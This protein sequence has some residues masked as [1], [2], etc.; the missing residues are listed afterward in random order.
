[1]QDCNTSNMSYLLTNIFSFHHILG[2]V[3]RKRLLKEKPMKNL[4]LSVICKIYYLLIASI[5]KI[6]SEQ[7]SS[8]L[9]FKHNTALT[10]PHQVK[11]I[12]NRKINKVG[13]DEDLVGW[14]WRNLVQSIEWLLR[15]LVIL[16]LNVFLAFT[17]EP[18]PMIAWL[19]E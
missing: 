12:F 10:P 4:K 14:N 8:S 3:S 2:K 13:I 5:Y 1:M 9:F 18:M 17:K 15:W 19:S 16:D 11:L 7:T 6:F